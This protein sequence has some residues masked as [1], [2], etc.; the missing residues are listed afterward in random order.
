[1][2][3]TVLIIL[4]V[5]V[6]LITLLLTSDVKISITYLNNELT[7]Y[8]GFLYLFKIPLYP[9]AQ[10]RRYMS[11]KELEKS[12]KKKKVKKVSPQKNKKDEDEKKG[13]SFSDIR[14]MLR[15]ILELIGIVFKRFIGRI[16]FRFNTLDITVA[17]S[18]AATTALT[19]AAVCS[20]LDVL[21]DMLSDKKRVNCEFVSPSVECDFL[22]EKFSAN[23]DILISVRIWQALCGA[24]LAVTD[25]LKKI[26]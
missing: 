16:K 21:L 22:A 4:A 26:M 15:E 9:S 24:V 25:K 20:T 17:A 23:I 11:V 2:G 12:S 10:P 18:D 14:D 7:A 19:Y 1:M 6:L 13:K 5:V 8:C 3:I